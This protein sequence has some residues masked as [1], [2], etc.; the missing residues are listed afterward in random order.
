MSPIADIAGAIPLAADPEDADIGTVWD[1]FS[2]AVLALT[3]F[4]LAVLALRG[5]VGRFGDAARAPRAR[6]RW[7]GAIGYVVGLVAGAGLGAWVA[8]ESGMLV[9]IGV[10]LGL[11]GSVVAPSA[12]AAVRLWFAGRGPARVPRVPRRPGHDEDV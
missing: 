7:V 10:A 1:S 9:S 11:A 3:I 5:A 12:I 6:G 8:V 4:G 2:E